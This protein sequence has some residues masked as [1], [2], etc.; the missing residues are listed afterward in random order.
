MIS[1]DT[2]PRITCPQSYVV[3]LVEEQEVYEINFNRSRSQV[4][5]SDDTDDVSIVVVTSQIAVIRS[6][7]WLR[8]RSG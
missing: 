1:D 4:S 3:E 2:P 6:C 5:V 8:A 7:N